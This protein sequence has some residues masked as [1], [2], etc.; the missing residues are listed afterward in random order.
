M[1]RQSTNLQDA[2]VLVTSANVENTG[3]G[4]GFV[5]HQDAQASYVL[6][7]AH[8]LDDLEAEALQVARMPATVEARGTADGVDL[9][10]LR[11]EGLLARSPLRLSSTGTQSQ[12][13][14]I[15]GFQ[16]YRAGVYLLRP[17]NGALGSVVGL[18]TRQGNVRVKAW[19][20]KIADEYFL[21]PGYSGSP[22]IDEASQQ[23]VGIVSTRQGEGRKGVAIAAEMLA[24]IWHNMPRSLH[25][26]STIMAPE[27]SSTNSGVKPVSTVPDYPTTEQ[28]VVEPST[29]REVD[30]S[31]TTA[32]RR[33][34]ILTALRLE[35]M[36]VR[37]HLGNFREEVYDNT[38]YEIGTFST[39]QQTW[40]VCI[41]EI[42][43]GNEKAALAAQNA[44]NYFKP[45]VALF[46]G[47][48]G[49]LKEVIRGDVVCAEKIYGYE[50][51]KDTKEGFKIRPEVGNSSFSMVERAK[52]EGRKDDWQKRIQQP[53]DITPTVFIAAI[54]AGEKVVGP[55][56]VYQFLRDN[57]SDAIAVDME[58]Y[59]FSLAMQR[60]PEIN[61]LVIRGISDLIRGKGAAADKKWQP[62]AARNA[63]AFAF[64]M[65]AKLSNNGSTGPQPQQTVTS[66]P[67]QATTKAEGSGGN[68]TVSPS[69]NAIKI[70]YAYS[71]TDTDEKYVNYLNVHLAGLR[72]RNWIT[73]SAQTGE[74]G[75]DRIEQ[76]NR[77][78]IILLLISPDFIDSGH[79]ETEAKRALERRQKENVTV[80]PIILRPTPDWR[81]EEFGN[82]QAIPRGNKAVSELERDT[83]LA[84]IAEEI[85]VIVQKIRNTRGIS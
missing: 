33:A 19:D 54:A 48:A 2:V 22:V 52:A 13:I 23:V 67:T 3:F 9:A 17:L 56:S 39:P 58:G 55:S 4:T 70:F 40:E 15:L 5:I 6:T 45:S 78:D 73:T 16:S 47:V 28:E 31:N 36:A 30:M 50:F 83:T 71:Q 37:A 11:V 80:I 62:I 49:G 25:I 42:G 65:L 77:A 81:L 38:V 12:H 1:D 14:I 60:K 41:A 10:V 68:A 72:R 8:I 27:S 32:V 51:G 46:V 24:H 7:C 84:K 29:I 26:S 20:L 18:E 63:S 69:D 64:E 66:Q 34:V 61:A 79:Y 35:Y 21:Q 74:A 53:A 75:E 44:M 59:G 76:L 43:M 85:R 82:L 57:Y